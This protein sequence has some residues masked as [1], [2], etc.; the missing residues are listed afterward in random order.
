MVTGIQPQSQG[1]VISLAQDLAR[2]NAERASAGL[3]ALRVPVQTLPAR[4][5]PAPTRGVGHDRALFDG[6][7]IDRPTEMV[8]TTIT[9]LVERITGTRD[10]RSGKSISQVLLAGQQFV[11]AGLRH[12]AQGQGAIA[13]GSSFLGKV[14][15]SLGIASGLMQVWKGWNELDSH[16]AGPLSILGSRTGRTGLLNV[17]AGALL[18]VP[19]V[20]T[21]LAGA[22]TRLVAAANEYDAL[23]FLDAP[24]RRV[25]EQG[26]ATARRVH[27]LDRTPTD[28]YD[29]PQLS[30]R[31]AVR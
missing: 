2:R 22:A 18:F 26:E 5:A 3:P 14:L 27:V 13:A 21:A 28:P 6:V 7:T 8:S 15:P 9:N 1:R 24:A 4:S 10:D 30:I 12:A 11:Q 17:V 23:S 31:R 25:E 29:R 20:G 16:E 19:G